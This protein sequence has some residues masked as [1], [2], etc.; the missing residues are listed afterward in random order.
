MK[1]I[2]YFGNYKIFLYFIF[3]Y[4]IQMNI[5]SE[6]YRDRIV[7]PMETAIHWIEYV[8]LTKGA[9]HLHSIATHY[10][11]FYYYNLD[12]WITFLF[13]LIFFLVILWKLSLFSI[14]S[15]KYPK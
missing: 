10:H 8:A 13:I 4:A 5:T 9:S 7:S 6:R 2:K 3:S 11:T 15:M 12:V 14:H 1:I